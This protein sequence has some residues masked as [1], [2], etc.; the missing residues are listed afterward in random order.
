M[1]VSEVFTSAFNAGGR[2]GPEGERWRRDRDG[3]WREHRG[4]DEDDGRGRYWHWDN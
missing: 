4:H 2:R 3:R 1:Q